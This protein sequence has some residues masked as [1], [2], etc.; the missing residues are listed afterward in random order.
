[1]LLEWIERLG[2]WGVVVWVVVTM[3]RSNERDR[4]DHKEEV[5]AIIDAHDRAITKFE[6]LNRAEREAHSDIKASLTRIEERQR[7]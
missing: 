1:M 2:G 4:A 7:A 6:D 5:V 3:M